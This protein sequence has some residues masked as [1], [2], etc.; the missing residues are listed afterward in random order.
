MQ[1]Y[2]YQGSENDRLFEADYD[3][4]RN[5]KGC[6]NCDKNRLLVRELR[7]TADPVIH[8]GLIGSANQVMKHGTTREKFRQEKGIICFEMEAAG[9]ID[10]FPC[11]V[12]RG[13]YDY[14]DTHK[15]KL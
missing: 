6:E 10:N 1:K 8:Y 15:N 7:D 14:S 2:Q 13:I 9:L 4:N 3:H 12:I 11:L 5:G